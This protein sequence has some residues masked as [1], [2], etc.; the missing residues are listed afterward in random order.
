MRKKWYD[1][2]ASLAP[3]GGAVVGAT[4]SIDQEIGY[5][6]ITAKSFI[7]A[8]APY[9]GKPLEMN[10]NSPGGSVLDALAIF[11]YLQHVHGADVKVNVLGIAASAATILML[12]GSERTI[13][14]HALV[15]VHDIQS[16]GY[17]TPSEMQDIVDAMTKIKATLASI[18]TTYTGADQATVDTWMAKDTWFTA[19]EAL[20]AGLVTQVI[21][22]A[23]VQAQ[24]D[25][26]QIE[27]SIP[28][29]LRDTVKASLG[30][31]ARANTPPVAP[32]AAQVPPVTPP[33]VVPAPQAVSESFVA[34][35]KAACTAAALP[36]SAVQAVVLSAKLPTDP[37][38]V[39]NFVATAAEIH[40][41][42][43]LLGKDSQFSALLVA[44]D[45]IADA[46]NKLIEAAASAS[47]NIDPHKPAKITP[48]ASAAWDALVKAHNDRGQ[49]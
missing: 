18:Y 5:W 6:G 13:A 45:T 34:K 15:M 35:V 36:E 49:R 27:A 47:T 29:A 33:P 32:A 43:A 20:T 38:A 12:A 3:D 10:I 40:G 19:Q 9:K 28:E 21:E 26:A 2:K 24:F 30:I 25:Y 42:C 1:I 7:D 37:T 48:S 17:G 14:A 16:G 23:P 8:I 11:N 22:S 31:Q 44:C 41:L 39:D 46:R 4:I